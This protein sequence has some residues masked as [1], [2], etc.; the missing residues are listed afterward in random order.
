M[1]MDLLVLY[2]SIGLGLVKIFERLGYS[3]SAAMVLSLLLISNRPLSMREICKLTGL[4]IGSVSMALDR[5]EGD[6][7]I[8]YVK[9]GRMKY[10]HAVKSL[11]NI[12]KSIYRKIL[13]IEELNTMIHKG[14]ELAGKGY[15][16]IKRLIEDLK[17]LIT[18]NH[19]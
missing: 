7:L 17:Q 11:K 2:E 10:Y 15:T 16:H 8:S 9:R 1:A 4:S 18:S 12:I 19:I 3:H 5:L 13:P 14:E 6:S